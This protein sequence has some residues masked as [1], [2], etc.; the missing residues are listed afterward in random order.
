MTDIRNRKADHIALALQPKHQAQ[1]SS[2]FDRLRFEPNPLPQMALEDINLGSQFL[3]QAVAAPFLIGAMTGGCDNGDLINQ[4]LAEAAQ[5]CAIPMALGSQRAA[6]EQGLAQN[7]RRW[8]PTAI[9][10][11]NLGATQIQQQGLD[12]AKRAVDSVQANG[13][14]IHL[15]PLQELIQP[16]GDRDWNLVLEAIQHC[17]VELEVP[18]IVKEVGAGI[19]PASAKKL[20]DAGVN[21][22][23]VAGRGGTSWASIELDRNGS[24]REREI[25]A[26]FIDWGMDTI[27]L[28][29]AVHAACPSLGLIG[30]GGVR[31]GLDIA[32]CIRLGAQMTALAQPFLAP[33][34][35]SAEAVVEKMS[36]L[37]EQLRWAMFLTGSQDISDLRKAPIQ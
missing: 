18:I 8:A 29:P 4:H 22:V 15:N 34:L 14:M 37:Q 24:E 3:D 12:L 21:W 25:A 26:P 23:E 27:E 31:H 17:A 9:L 30:S 35:E 5:A 20:M 19:G 11:G 28:L 1:Q 36:T 32:R 6:L 13:L 33:A 10:L 16:N 7:V 2:G